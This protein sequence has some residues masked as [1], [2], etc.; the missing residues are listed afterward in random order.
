MT[1][2]LNIILLEKAGVSTKGLTD[3]ELIEALTRVYK[4]RH[5]ELLKQEKETKRL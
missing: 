4:A 3:K 5:K 1:R 2:E